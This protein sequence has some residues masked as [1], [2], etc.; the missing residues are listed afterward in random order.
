MAGRI[1]SIDYQPGALWPV[2]AIGLHGIDGLFVGPADLTVAY[3]ADADAAAKLE[4]AL[5]R[6]GAATQAHGKAYMSFVADTAKAAE[7]RK[8]GMT[9]FY[10]AS[11]HGFML[12]AARGAAQGIHGL[13]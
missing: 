2:N 4:T 1:T 12:S 7:W 9:M 6:V 3:G 11:E 10:V 5:A 13:D 8:Y